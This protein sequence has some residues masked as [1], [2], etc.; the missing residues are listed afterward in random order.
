MQ[1]GARPVVV[2]LQAKNPQFSEIPGSK[3]VIRAELDLAQLEHDERG[4]Y[5]PNDPDHAGAFRL[6]QRR[7]ADVERGSKPVG[8]T[9]AGSQVKVL[10]DVRTET[11]VNTRPELRAVGVDRILDSE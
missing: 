11:S 2:A 1:L 8:P 4:V 7:P 6:R 9:G 3:V 10:Q 5:Q